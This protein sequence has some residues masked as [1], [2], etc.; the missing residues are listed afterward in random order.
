MALDVEDTD[1][2][3]AM[4][5]INGTRDKS[6][7]PTKEVQDAKKMLEQAKQLLNET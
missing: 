1:I 7:R 6:G 2:Q 5:I 3:D 4:D